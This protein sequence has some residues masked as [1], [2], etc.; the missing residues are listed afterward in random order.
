MI[1]QFKTTL[2]E[3]G[4]FPLPLSE[5][6]NYPLTLTRDGCIRCP[7]CG[8]WSFRITQYSNITCNTCESSYQNLGVFGL[9]KINL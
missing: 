1:K 2:L 5:N 8:D 7:N 4:K 6:G 9:T 3:L